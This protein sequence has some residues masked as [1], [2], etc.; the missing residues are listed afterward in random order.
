V[1]DFQQF[2][3]TELF[4]RAGRSIRS[5]DIASRFMRFARLMLAELRA[6]LDE[7]SALTS[8]NGGRIEIGTLPMARAVF[9][10]DLLTSFMAANPTATVRVI[11]AP[12]GELLNALRQGDIDLIIGGALR[13]PPPSNDI[14]QEILFDDEQVVVG[15]ARHPLRRRKNLSSAD[16]LHFPWIIPS[17]GVP[18]RTNWERM[19]RDS[20]IEPPEVRIECGSMLIARGLMLKG[21]WLTLMS[22]DQIRLE[23]DAGMLAEIDAPGEVLRRRIV[24]TRRHDWRPTALQAQ[25]VDMAH[26]CAQHRQSGGPR[27]EGKAS[28]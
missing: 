7:I 13:E 2:L 4:V 24:L 22:R 21:N 27:R 17:S 26:Q 25:L 5:T 28:R 19:F 6:G 1:R 18:M 16:L 23:C 20:G 15:N 14:V 12:Y 11:E 3:G 10:P 8:G 9:L